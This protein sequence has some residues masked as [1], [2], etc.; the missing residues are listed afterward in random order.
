MSKQETTTVTTTPAETEEAPIKEPVTPEPL[1]PEEA[2]HVVV[3]SEPASAQDVRGDVTPTPIPTT[4]R[5]FDGDYIVTDMP[6]NDDSF[7]L[8]EEYT[9]VVET[10]DNDKG[11]EVVNTDDVQ[12]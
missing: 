2:A 9:Q 11:V 7:P 8:Q 3:E 12:K 4:N 6:D 10:P 1:T 5:R